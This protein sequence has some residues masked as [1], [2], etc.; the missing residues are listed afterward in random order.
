MPTPKTKRIVVLQSSYA[1]ANVIAN[2]NVTMNAT[3]ATPSNITAVNVS[4]EPSSSS[5]ETSE[6]SMTF[7]ITGGGTVGQVTLSFNAEGQ[8]LATGVGVAKTSATTTTVPRSTAG[9]VTPIASP[10]AEHSRVWSQTAQDG[11]NELVDQVTGVDMRVLAGSGYTVTQTVTS[12][13]DDELIVAYAWKDAL[14]ATIVSGTVKLEAV[15]AAQGSYRLG[16][17]VVV[18]DPPQGA[19]RVAGESRKAL[20]ERTREIMKEIRRRRREARGR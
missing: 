19:Q 6:Y 20:R 7:S 10:S 11:A 4:E 8:D 3:F 17:V 14:G 13:D 1:P 5:G 16:D 18:D 15:A 12:W 9:T 2:L